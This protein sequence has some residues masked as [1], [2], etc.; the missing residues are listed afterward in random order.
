MV[1]K[2]KVKPGIIELHPL[3]PMIVVNYEMQMVN[4]D[5]NGH[6]Q[7]TE[8]QHSQKKIKIK[9]LKPNSNINKI[10]KGVIEHC[11]Y[12][13]PSKERHIVS[14]LHALKQRL[15][16]PQNSDHK[17]TQNDIDEHTQNKNERNLIETQM[18]PQQTQMQP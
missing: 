10:A 2:K 13:P 16:E 11:K 14:L 5:E 6:S 7:I 18:Q 8:K 4:T 15:F 12:I 17:H 3:E 1:R 9:A